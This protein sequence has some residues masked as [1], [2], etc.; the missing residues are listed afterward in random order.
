VT[1]SDPAEAFRSH[2]NYI[3][4]FAMLCSV[5]YADQPG[6]H[7]PLDQVLA[8][9]APVAAAAPSLILPPGV[10]PDRDQARASLINAWGTELLLAFGGE[11][12][13]EDELVRLMNNWAVVQAYYAAYHAIQALIVTRG[14]PR[15]ESHPKTQNQF[16][17]M[18]TSRTLQ[19]PPWSLAAC[20]EGWTNPSR[21]IDGD[22]HPWSGCDTHNC[23]DLAAKVMRTTRDEKVRDA[24]SKARDRK[25]KEQRKVWMAEEQTRLAAGKRARKEP[26]FSR[27]R[28]TTDE[29]H[30]LNK[31][32]RACT[33]LDYLYRLRVKAN[34][35]DASMFVAGPED[36]TSSLTVHSD[37]VGLTSSTLLVHELHI[38]AGV[39]KA[40]L[41]AWV[42]EWLGRNTAGTSIGLGLRRDLLSEH[43]QD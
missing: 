15:P 27:P 6:L 42:D 41:L 12:A 32:V 19:L 24:E 37:L 5:P 8:R 1:P 17:D 33:V 11:V 28:L 21:E 9:L 40:T 3:R 30:Q 29:K 39:G 7:A 31:R 20:D 35:E 14:N 38:G 10:E 34:Y 18:W 16:A 22:I 25:Q 43:L 36:E 13:R 2:A 26:R 23:W 4:A